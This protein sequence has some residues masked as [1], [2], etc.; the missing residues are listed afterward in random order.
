MELGLLTLVGVPCA[1]LILGIVIGIRL[2]RDVI[3]QTFMGGVQHG[4]DTTV[5][6]IQEQIKQPEVIDDDQTYGFN[7]QPS[8][9]KEH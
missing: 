6:M 7:L 8:K 5:Q 4:S 9:G 2:K 3:I 1:T